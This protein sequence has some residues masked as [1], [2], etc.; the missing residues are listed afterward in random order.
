MTNTKVVNIDI[1]DNSG[2]VTFQS[3]DGKKS[4]NNYDKILVCVGRSPNTKNLAIESTGIKLNKEGFIDINSQCRT[5]IPNIFAIGDVTGNPMLAHRATHQGKVVAETIN[6]SSQSF[7]PQCIPY[8]IFTDPEIAW[9]GPSIK[10]LEKT[11]IDFASKT[12]P[13]Q[14]NARA[15]S[16]GALYGKTKIIYS[17][18]TNKVLS[19]GIIGPSAGDLIG[20]AALAIEMGALVEDIALTIHP[21]PT[22]TETIANTAEMIEGTVTDIYNPKR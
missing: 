6:G 1:L 16:L 2:L 22:L 17:K 19:V 8:V 13:W 21:H 5:L 9:A 7:D 11:Q 4:L 14:A 3:K 20:E 12:F 15:I 18:N 10:E